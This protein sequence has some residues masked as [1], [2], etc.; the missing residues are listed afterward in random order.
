MNVLYI[1]MMGMLIPIII[2]PI[3]LGIKHARYLREVEHA[4]KMRAMELGHS[5]HEEHA[6]TSAS[7]A[8][9]IG[10]AV[11]IA[12]MGIAFLAT[13]SFAASD[14]SLI[15]GIWQTA[16]MIGVAGVICGSILAAQGF[17]QKHQAN[18]A[19]KPEFD[20]EAFDVVG[21]RG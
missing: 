10:G 9:L 1:P 12:A 8:A 15:H 4:E 7:L 11:P 16:A 19:E 17:A 3:S 6:W 13:R 20:P 14:T 18:H 5:P 21:R 2:V